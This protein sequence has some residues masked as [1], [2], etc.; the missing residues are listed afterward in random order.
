[1]NNLSKDQET[2]T[3]TLRMPDYGI[4]QNWTV[5]NKCP[6]C[7][8]KIVLLG[9]QSACYDGE[10]T[11]VDRFTCENECLIYYSDMLKYNGV[12]S[13]LEKG[14]IIQKE[15]KSIIKEEVL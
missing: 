4:A 9:K 10:Y 8:S 13:L 3:I 5:M 14:K 6:H 2:N 12:F 11:W 1:M 7:G 15:W